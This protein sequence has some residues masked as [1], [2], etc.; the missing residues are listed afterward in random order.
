MRLIHEMVMSARELG[1][2]SLL[3]IIPEHAPRL[4]RRVGLDCIP[5]GPVLDTGGMR[6]VCVTISMQTRMH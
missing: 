3:G 5:A 1:A 2:A 6:S 4:A